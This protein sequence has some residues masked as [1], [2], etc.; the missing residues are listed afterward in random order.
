MKKLLSMLLAVVLLAGLLPQGWGNSQVFAASTKGIFFIFPNEQYDISTPRI[1]NSDRLTVTGS[2]SNINT[3]S[4]TY[5]VEQISKDGSNIT[6]INSNKGLSGNVTASTSGGSNLTISDI[7]LFAGLNRITF[8]ATQGVSSQVAESIYVDYRNGPTLYNLTAVL[9]NDTVAL[10]ENTPVVLTSAKGGINDGQQTANMSLSGSAPNA[11]K[12]TV[13]VN[14]GSSRTSIVSSANNYQFTVAPIALKSG[15]N[16]LTIQAINGTQVLETTRD[17]TFYNGLTT[18]YDTYAQSAPVAIS[19]DLSSFPDYSV[20]QNSF[21]VTGKVVVPLVGGVRPSSLTDYISYTFS[22]AGVP[23]NASQSDYIGKVTPT[24]IES[25]STTAYITL[26]YTIPDTL[27]TNSGVKRTFN[28]DKGINLSIGANNSSSGG[29]GLT[30]RNSAAAYIYKVNYL[31]G[32]TET[33]S[34]DAAQA[35]TGTTLDGANIFSLPTALEVLVVNGADDT[36]LNITKVKDGTG[37]E[38]ALTSDNLNYTKISSESIVQTVNGN[39]QRMQRLLYRLNKVPVNGTQTLTFTA[40]TGSVTTP[41]VTATINVLFGPY[42]SF[43]KAYD[44]MLIPNSQNVPG[45]AT[46]IITNTLDNFSGKLQNVTT[47]SDIRYADGGGK[48]QTVF[49]YVNNTLIPL[50]PVNGANDPNFK[51]QDINKAYSAMFSGQNVIKLVF[52]TDKTSYELSININLVPTDVPVIPVNTTLG[53]FPFKYTGN[54]DAIPTA[55]DPAFTANGTAYTT[56]ETKFNIYGTFDFVDLGKN[57]G[58]VDSLLKDNS[59]N[60]IKKANYILEITNSTGATVATWTLNNTFTSISGETFNSGSPAATA[61]G[62][63]LSV[64]YDYNSQSFSFI[65]R[66]QDVPKDGSPLVYNFTVYNT[67]KGGPSSSARMEI[68]QQVDTYSIVRPL[69]AQMLTNSNFIDVVINSKTATSVVIN[70]QT[71]TKAPFYVDPDGKAMGNPPEYPDAYKV[72][73]TDLKPN[74]DTKIP[75]IVTIAGQ[76]IKD[77]VVVRYVP[78]NI[79]GA[80]FMQVMKT[81]AK[82][83]DGD[84]N[85]KFPT[86]TNLIRKD[87]G[88]SADDKRKNEVFSGNTLLFGIGNSQDGVIDRY[89]FEPTPTNMDQKFKVG[90]QIFVNQFNNHFVKSSPVFWIDPGLA[91]NLDSSDYDP[92]TMGQKPYQPTNSSV[93]SFYER[94]PRNELVPSKRG[95]LTLSYSDSVAEDAGKLVTVFFF[96]RSLGNSSGQ[97]ENIGGVVNAKAHTIT[98]PFDRFGYYVVAKLSYSYTDIVQHS[99]ARDYMEA[100][101]AKGIM[102]A[103]DPDSS[104]GADQYITRGEFTRAIVRAMQLPFD[105]QGPKHFIDVSS[106]DSQILPDALYDYRYIE[107]A[108]RAGFIRGTQP[109]VFSPGDSITRQDAAVIIA[110]ALNLK[111]QTDQTKIDA[112][113]QK[114]FKDASTVDRYARASVLA[115]AKQ[116]LISGSAIDGDAKKGFNFTPTAK[117]LR[118]DTAVILAKVMISDKKL[119]PM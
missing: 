12:V 2:Y 67:G 72:T 73:V 57:F 86:G 1:A 30:L 60:A 8:R 83:F 65:V 51:I 118:S 117:M 89:N 21:T 113:L 26:Q 107:T 75:V 81:S 23:S 111:L 7:P 43:N 46:R 84:V 17:V 16:T 78:T 97:W 4:I 55:A 14:G 28:Y 36:Q 87:I 10:K 88:T 92:V 34:Q 100:L 5:D 54:S 119:P 27:T 101:F 48:T 99:Y 80:E 32:Y 3:N 69:Q 77:E 53:I 70:K 102:K 9:D 37:A 109:Q 71:A 15:K 74:K 103:T 110:K 22:G 85:L 93:P 38:A 40:T 6:V 31:A 68:S 98:V 41:E 90:Q 96:D 18:F 76:K 19:A 79:P 91:D 61:S 112:A 104:F 52:K 24:I 56:K 44:G 66:G 13:L 114:V 58:S 62:T 64:F 95:T 42:A 94:D 47:Q 49:F 116:G 105:Y 63:G 82:V 25:A 20:S 106:N 45:A 59:A 33:T 50:I 108:A 39:S 35:M 29:F 115:V 11:A